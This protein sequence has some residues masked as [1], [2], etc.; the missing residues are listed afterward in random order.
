MIMIK[1]PKV[2]Y[3][4]NSSI[5]LFFKAND[6]FAF[7]PLAVSD[8]LK[9]VIEERLNINLTQIGVDGS[10]LVGLYT[11]MN[12]HGIIASNVFQEKEIAVLRSVA[13]DYD[14]N[15]HVSRDVNNANG[16]NICVNDNGGIINPDISHSEARKMSDVLG[17]ELVPMDIAGYKTV[18]SMCIAT[19]KGFVCHNDVAPEKIK[20]LERI[21]KVGGINST[22]NFGVPFVGTG[23][24]ANSYGYVVGSEST[25][26]EIQR[27][28][29]G[30][31]LV[32]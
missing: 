25:G 26:V 29:E 9:S 16:N 7:S 31:D 10:D 15:V 24:L 23:I 1:P 32:R 20:E 13:K 3:F 4:G 18:G 28:E 17:V 27:V 11:A 8:K 21:F 19:N 30:L 2:D 5:S 22:I 12:S 6:L 14:V